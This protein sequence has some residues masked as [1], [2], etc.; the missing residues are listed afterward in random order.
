MTKTE[1]NLAVKEIN[2]ALNLIYDTMHPMPKVAISN[3]L[4]KIKQFLKG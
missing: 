1:K 4:S 3:I 2:K